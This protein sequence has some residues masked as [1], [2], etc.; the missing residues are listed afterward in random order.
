MD[1]TTLPRP[2]SI[3]EFVWDVMDRSQQELVLEKLES[4]NA[5]IDPGL[6]RAEAH[7]HNPDTDGPHELMTWNERNL[8]LGASRVAN[9]IISRNREGE[10]R[11]QD[12][13]RRSGEAR[14]LEVRERSQSSLQ[15]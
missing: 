13:G 15:R 3:P 6:Q 4:Q 5:N 8:G 1:T 7:L 10:V 14:G 2:L 12:R 9:G 11:R